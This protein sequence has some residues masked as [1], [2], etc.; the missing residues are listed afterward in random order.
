MRGICRQI[1]EL[2]NAIAEFSRKMN[3]ESSTSLLMAEY[4]IMMERKENELLE[5]LSRHDD[6]NN[7]TTI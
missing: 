1:D 5:F 6:N 3:G 7:N 2:E 4:Q